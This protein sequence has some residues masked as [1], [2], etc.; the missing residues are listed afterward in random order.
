[1]TIHFQPAR[2]AGRTA[3]AGLAALM[4]CASAT[5][6]VA[7]DAKGKAASIEGVWKVTH[8]VF[9]GAN[10]L[11]VNSPQENLTIFSRGHYASVG[12]QSE[13]PRTAA[14]AFKEPGKPTDAE[15]LAKYEEWAPLGAQAG[16][17]EL[18]AGKVTR[19]PIVAKNVA[20]MTAGAF[21]SDVK[22]LTADTLVLVTPAPAG[23]PA[24]EQTVTY[25]RVK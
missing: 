8:V 4:L 9:T 19:T 15:K 5:G 23:Q 10:P 14:P 2:G 24:R 11:T 3:L 13:K 1:M 12:N 16:T 7:A 17:Y 25:S 20:T 18:K 6:A 21:T 22:T